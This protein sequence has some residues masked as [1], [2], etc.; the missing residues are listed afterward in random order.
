[1]A[2]SVQLGLPSLPAAAGP[3]ERGGGCSLQAEGLFP[4]SWAAAGGWRTAALQR[5]F[6]P[7]GRRR[8]G[9]C[10]RP[11]RMVGRIG[12]GECGDR[13]GG[14]DGGECGWIRGERRGAWRRAEVELPSGSGQGWDLEEGCGTGSEVMGEWETEKTAG[15][16][17]EIGRAHV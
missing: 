9:F 8:G 5:R 13:A 3:E 12:G 11:Q 7:S 4:L 14:G 16:E 15:R 10:R 2:T 17:R 1:M 6:T